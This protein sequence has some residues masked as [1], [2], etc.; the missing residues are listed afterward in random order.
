MPPGKTVSL[1]LT[2]RRKE[3]LWH[4]AYSIAE[5]SAR[6][7]RKMH[8]MVL[9]GPTDVSEIVYRLRRARLVRVELDPKHPRRVNI[10][11]THL[12]MDV[13]LGNIKC[14]DPKGGGEVDANQ[15]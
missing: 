5:W 6:E 10:I 12:G 9:L 7:Y 11:I 15:G 2:E 8:L 1:N 14:V 3:V 4:A 13:L